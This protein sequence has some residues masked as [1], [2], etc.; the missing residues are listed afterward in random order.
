LLYNLL[1]VLHILCAVAA[2][3][4]NLTYSVWFARG[5]K[6]T[7]HLAFALGGIRTLDDWV[8]N[9]AYAGLGLSGVGMVLAGGLPWTL[10]WVW[11]GAALLVLTSILGLGVYSPLLRR[12]IA[13][14]EAG[15]PDSGPYRALSARGMALGMVFGVLNLAVFF[16]MVFKPVL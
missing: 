3:G 14:L 12:Q 10:A 13:A 2:V 1:K 15:G 7:R 6:D 9:P 11:M 4:S 8:S 5:A 16:L